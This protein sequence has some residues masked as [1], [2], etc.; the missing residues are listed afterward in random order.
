MAELPRG[1]VTFL[2]TDIEGSTVRWEHQ[3]EAMRASLAR[4][5]ALVRAAIQDHHGHVVK[6]MGDAFHAVFVRAPDAVAAAV[7]AQR[8]LQ[9]EPWGEVGP[10]RVR[11]AVHTG[12]AE[13]RDGDYYG[14]PLNRAARLTSTGHGGQILVSQAT[15]EL[16][17]DGPPD[18]ITFVDLG[19]HRLKD[20]IRP[21]RVFQVAGDGLPFGFP[22]IAS[23]NARTHNLPFQT[24]PLLGRDHEIQA[25]RSLL[26]DGDTRL[27]TLTGPGGTG[28]TCLSLQV[29]AEL[30]DHFGDGV[31]FVE[32]API[33]DPALVPATIAQVLGVRDVGGRPVLDSLKDYLRAREILLV[34]D[35]FE[36]VLPAATVVSDLL[37]ASQ[38]L[39][40]LV[41]SRAPLELRGE[42]EF[43]LPPL[44]LP[45]LRRRSTV[46]SVSQYAAVALFIERATAIR[47]DFAVTNE[48]APTVAEICHRLDGLPLAIELAAARIRLLT[49]EAML[50]RLERRLPLLTGGSRDLPARQQTLRSAIAWSYDL[51][52]E[53]E[54]ALFRRLASFVGGC[55]LDAA[56]AVCNGEGDLEIDVLDGVTSLVA[57][58]LLRQLDGPDGEPRFGM[59]ETIREFASEQLDARG[60]TATLRDRHLAHYLAFAQAVKPELQGPRQAVSFDRLER[61]NDNLRAALEWSATPS[62]QSS[63]AGVDALLGMS[64]VE[65]GT[66][67]AEALGFFWVLRGRGRENLPRVMALVAQTTPGTPTRARAVTSAAHVHGHMLGN[68]ETA[69]P[70]ADEGLRTWR[71]LGDRHGIAIALVRRGQIAFETGD[72]PLA[73]TLLS[74]ARALLREIGAP[75]GPEVPTACWLAEVA[76]AQGDLDRTQQL[77]VEVLAE[78][79]AKGDSHVI[80][81][82]LREM[83]R[84][85]RTQGDAERA[86]TLLHESAVLLA[87]V[88]D[89]RCAAVLV[90]DLAGSLCERGQLE[91][92]ARLFA[93]AETLRELI[94]KPLTRGQLA[95]HGRD[96]ATVERQLDPRVFA[97]A[98]AEG[99]AMTLEQALEY[100]LER[101]APA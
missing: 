40:V 93:A 49:P 4:H 18:G 67:L 61:E 96:L 24:A 100:A 16:V 31:F 19:E 84:L 39:K 88:K 60:E 57:R 51:L 8:K 59:L 2:F 87:P 65:A 91:D 50:S 74:D 5:D 20:L 21:E 94:G 42:H 27:L 36:Q 22:S 77:Y 52:H 44:A 7:D 72:Y 13:E 75:S 99:Q 62:G 46:E 28:K 66:R 80:A 85:H 98:W 95:T 45:D 35:N 34:I 1:T 90:E 58:S 9:A 48:T 43:P 69:L 81:H 15:Y 29:A 30:I 26:L 71:A 25:T 47:P 63:S 11:M 55:T 17:R 3:P 23:L 73:T 79:R 54:R 53:A 70:F 38:G 37:R 92:A 89:V 56:E 32:L 78:A 83:A 82:V 64:R 10:I 76:Q 6:T 41:T 12:T 97:A 14:P 86:F 101:S 68:Y 33:F